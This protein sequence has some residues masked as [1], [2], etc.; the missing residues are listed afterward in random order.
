M[1]WFRC[2]I[3]RLS[4]AEPAGGMESEREWSRLGTLLRSR[5]QSERAGSIHPSSSSN[6]LCRPA[7]SLTC[8]GDPT[9]QSSVSP[10][11]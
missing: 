11:D 8:C 3:V 4:E 7:M 2:H 5:T 1:Q 10:V 6:S 9:V